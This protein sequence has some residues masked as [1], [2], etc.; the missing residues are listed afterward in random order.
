[1]AELSRDYRRIFAPVLFS[2][3]VVHQWRDQKLAN[4]EL[5]DPPYLSSVK[6]FTFAVDNIVE[7]DDDE[8][9]RPAF[10]LKVLPQM[11]NLRSLK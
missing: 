11:H 4:G 3:I 10:V 2:R 7:P 8:F 1:M 9:E 5:V 6:D